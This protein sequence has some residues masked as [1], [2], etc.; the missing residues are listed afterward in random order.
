MARVGVAGHGVEAV[1]GPIDAANEEGRDQT[2]DNPE[3]DEK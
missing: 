2:H 1:F 3:G